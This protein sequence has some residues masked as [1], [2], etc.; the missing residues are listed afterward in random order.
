[1]KINPIEVYNDY[2]IKKDA[3]HQ[4]ERK[5]DNPNS[6]EASSAGLCMKKHYYKKI[7]APKKPVDSD[8][9]RIMR[10]G[11]IMGED[12]A[13]ALDGIDSPNTEIYQELL[14][15]S[16]KLGVVGH[17]DLLIVEDGKG[18]LYDWKTANSF[19]FKKVF[20]ST[21]TNNSALQVGTYANAVLEMGVCEEIVHMGLLYF[22]KN[23]SKMKELILNM[24]NI[25]KAKKYWESTNKLVKYAIDDQM[26]PEWATG[27]V[28]VYKWECGKYCNYSK[29]CNCPLNK[30]YEGGIL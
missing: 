30:E 18:Y 2:L 10:L 22:N 27:S 4:I 21:E 12:F 3:E 29:I 20:T 14:V 13:K 17:L 24:D 5:K 26:E 23:D 25:D 11:T 7:E 9:L 15:E 6:F 8:S 1:M 28:P 16:K 19:K